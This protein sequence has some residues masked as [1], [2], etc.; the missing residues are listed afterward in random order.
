MW[1]TRRWQQHSERFPSLQRLQDRTDL[2]EFVGHCGHG[3]RWF[4][5]PNVPPF[6]YGDVREGAAGAPDQGV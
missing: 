2:L 6:L 4:P 5:C 3:E 1:K